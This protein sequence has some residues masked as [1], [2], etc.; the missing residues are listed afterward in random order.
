MKHTEIAILLG[1]KYYDQNPENSVN[2]EVVRLEPCVLVLGMQNSVATM[3]NG[4]WL[5]LKIINYII[6]SIFP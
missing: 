3:E 5:F 2:E 4:I 6:T 1:V